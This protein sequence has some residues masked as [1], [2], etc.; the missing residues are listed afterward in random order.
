MGVV[1][2]PEDH[3]AG[4]GK[5]GGEWV[6]HQEGQEESLGEGTLTW[7]GRGREVSPWVPES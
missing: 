5:M 7:A 2:C 3:A 4:V 1:R 6:L